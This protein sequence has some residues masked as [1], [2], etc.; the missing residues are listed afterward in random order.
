MSKEI[1]PK[2]LLELANRRKWLLILPTVACFLLSVLL[3]LTLPKFY[4]SSSL[5][6]VHP[7]E[8]SRDFIRGM[9][10][11][12]VSTDLQN[13]EEQIYSRNWME[14]V[15]RKLNPALESAEGQEFDEL[16]YRMLNRVYVETRGRT[17]FTISYNGKDA[18]TVYNVVQL[19]TDMF[20]GENVAQMAKADADAAFYLDEEIA[21]IEKE[22]STKEANLAAYK[23][24]HMGELPEQI[25]PNQRMLERLQ[26]QQQLH[27]EN[28]RDARNRQ[29]ILESQLMGLGE[30]GGGVGDPLIDELL[31]ARRV[32][33]DL[34]QQYTDNHPDV[35]NAQARIAI[36]EEQLENRAAPDAEGRAAGNDQPLAQAN[37]YNLALRSE[38][39]NV[40]LTIRR[41][42]DEEVR[43]RQ[44]IGRFEGRVEAAFDRQQELTQLTRDYENL[45]E[46]YR[47]LLDKKLNTRLSSR[48][49]QTHSANQYEVLD[50]PR[51]PR[52]PYFPDPII[53]LLIGIGCGL[54]IGSALIAGLELRNDAFFSSQLLE[55]SMPLPVLA[56]IP[57]LLDETEQ[58]RRKRK[59]AYIIST[60]CLVLLALCCV[61]LFLVDLV[62]ILRDFLNFV[63]Q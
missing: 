63:I 25:E 39:E 10:E 36:L 60:A 14:R 43:R 48:V 53:V 40:K 41:L 32:L 54:V 56:T 16:V 13:I 38:L 28:L 61:N 29:L 50:P 21:T 6:L 1:T 11:Y 51:V 62:G 17:S 5:I 30:A 12:D 23:Q 9:V 33:E 27:G 49:L 3:Y 57:V 45:E 2:F 31:Q 7:S 24:Q 20:I 55:E 18:E 15:V 58:R 35:I 34:K 4:E 8:L 19:L 42:E 52:Y 59:I 37:T 46:Y 47:T 26:M 22:L 44:E